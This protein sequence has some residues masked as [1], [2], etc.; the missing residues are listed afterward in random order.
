MIGD[1]KFPALCITEQTMREAVEAA[2][3]LEMIEWQEMA[4]ITDTQSKPT[5]HSGVYCMLARKV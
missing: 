3:H 5:G 4:R 1:K 2:K